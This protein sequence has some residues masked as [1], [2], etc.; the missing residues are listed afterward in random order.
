[1]Q[2]QHLMLYEAEVMGTSKKV[3]WDEVNLDDVYGEKSYQHPTPVL[4]LM[5][6]S[7]WGPSALNQHQFITEC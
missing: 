5:G 3:C 1:M 2:I 4:Y 6:Y 7:A